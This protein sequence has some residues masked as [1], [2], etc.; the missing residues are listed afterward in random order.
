MRIFLPRK[1]ARWKSSASKSK[2]FLL[3]YVLQ[4]AH[5]FQNT[6]I[7]LEASELQIAGGE[8]DFSDTKKGEWYEKTVELK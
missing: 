3:F 7:L 8:M 1:L 5:L 2:I 6:L 4:N